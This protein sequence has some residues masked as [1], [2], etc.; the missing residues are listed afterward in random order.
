[1]RRKTVGE[2]PEQGADGASTDLQH[3]AQS[4]GV[5]KM[6]RGAI[7]RRPQG[8]GG[9]GVASGGK[10]SGTG[11]DSKVATRRAPVLASQSLVQAVQGSLRINHDAFG[12]LAL[13]IDDTLVSQV[14]A[15]LVLGTS[16]RWR[17]PVRVVATLHF[18][19]RQFWAA[20]PKMAD[21]VPLAGKSAEMLEHF[22]SLLRLTKLESTV[23]N[24]GSEVKE[25]F[26]M[27]SQRKTG[28]CVLFWFPVDLAQ[29]QV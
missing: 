28:Q 17:A 24:H 29:K 7:E 22:R 27:T 11:Q 16:V 12:Q 1:L 19:Q 6:V 26:E 20:P 8:F 25:G 10:V 18:H 9:D 3:D 13:A 5:D 15:H 21:S 4:V 14:L 23:R 2:S